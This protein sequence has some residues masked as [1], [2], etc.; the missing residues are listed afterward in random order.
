MSTQVPKAFL[1]SLS[2]FFLVFTFSLTYSSKTF[3]FLEIRKGHTQNAPTKEF[4]KTFEEVAQNSK[5]L[6]HFLRP[7]KIVIVRGIF[8]NIYGDLSEKVQL[9]GSSFPE[10]LTDPFYHELKWLR[11]NGLDAVIANINSEGG[12]R[13]NGE[14][15]AQIIKEEQ[16]KVLLIGHSKGGIDT[17]FGLLYHPEIRDRVAGWLIL[18]APLYGS[19][20]LDCMVDCPFTDIALNFGLQLL[21]SHYR[22]PQ[23]ITS[24]AL[25]NFHRENSKEIIDIINDI[26]TLSMASTF[27]NPSLFSIPFISFSKKSA[28]ELFNRFIEFS[29]G[30]ENDG[31]TPLKSACLQGTECIHLQQFDHG[32]LVVDLSPFKAY[33]T[34]VRR[35]VFLSLLSMLKKRMSNKMN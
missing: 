3:S 26:P 4:Y 21:E 33:K 18:Q 19:P 14:A 15:I 12:S 10:G 27:K 29:G 22:T 13:A 9:T 30:G 16:K 32:N 6:I 5:E 31:M 35:S 8:T 24:K 1:S 20:L 34:P 7:Y 25:N 23:E 17:L 28:F 2:L 11:K